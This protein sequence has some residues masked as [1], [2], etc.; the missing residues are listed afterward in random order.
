MSWWE[1]L[2]MIRAEEDCFKKQNSQSYL[3]NQNMDGCDLLPGRDGVFQNDSKGGRKGFRNTL[4]P[5]SFWDI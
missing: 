4:T 1:E 3:E 2:G 5:L